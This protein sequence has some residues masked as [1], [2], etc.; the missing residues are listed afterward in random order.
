MPTDRPSHFRPG[1]VAPAGFRPE[2]PSAHVFRTARTKRCVYGAVT[3]ID[4]GTDRVGSVTGRGKRPVTGSVT[5][6][7]A[8]ETDRLSFARGG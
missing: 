6:A 8:P 1:G 7:K 5:R 3:G 4:T 2:T